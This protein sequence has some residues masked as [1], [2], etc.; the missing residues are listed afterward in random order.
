MLSRS[1]GKM[2][3]TV[4]DPTQVHYHLPKS[5]ERPEVRGVA[6]A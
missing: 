4:P 6:V 2:V 3:E 5:A 1:V